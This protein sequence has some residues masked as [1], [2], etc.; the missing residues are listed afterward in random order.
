MAA[1]SLNPEKPSTTTQ[2][3]SRMY[4]RQYRDYLE[5]EI[6]RMWSDDWTFDEAK[7]LIHSIGDPDKRSNYER[8]LERCRRN[9]EFRLRDGTRVKRD[10]LGNGRAGQYFKFN[11]ERNLIED[12]H[13]ILSRPGFG[14][15]LSNLLLRMG[16][17]RGQTQIKRIRMP[18]ALGLR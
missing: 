1:P 6:S 4:A 12:A 2:E 9:P 14:D 3:L 11:L 7:R 17:H 13:E 5:Y 16:T 18:D 15:L 8:V 10:I